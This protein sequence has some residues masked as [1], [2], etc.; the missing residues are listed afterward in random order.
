MKVSIIIGWLICTLG[1]LFY[2]YEYLLR[3]EPSVM[4]PEF[5]HQFEVTAAGLGLFTALYYY[6]YMPL[7]L[8]VGILID[9]FGTRIILTLAISSCAFGSFLFGSSHSIYAAGFG[10]F[11]IGF[12]SAFA[13]VGVL[14]LAAEWLPKHHFALFAGCAVA[15]GMVG[16]M[17][18]DVELTLLIQRVGW[19][20]T[21]YIG[22]VIGLILIPLIWLLVRDAP[23]WK[24]AR[25][26]V[27]VSFRDGF[28]GFWE[29]LR[30]PQ[31]WIAGTIGCMLYLSLS[32]FAELWGISFLEKVYALS[33]EKSALACSMVFAGWLIGAPLN[34]WLS[35]KNKTRKRPIFIGGFL[36]LLVITIVILKPINF[37]FYSLMSL[38]F[39][40]G[41]FS[42]V[43]IVCFAIGRENNPT[44]IA[45][46][47]VAFTNLLVMAGGVIFQ[48]L[49]GWLL[50]LNWNHKLFNGI[51]NYSVHDYQFTFLVLPICILISLFLALFLKDTL[52]PDDWDEFDK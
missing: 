19:R 50:D 46:T 24:L 39:L 47:A 12:G 30:N 33:A 18:G 36:S 32:A 45:A 20:H 8:V 17:V 52:R 14:K 44:R 1:A 16:A 7:Q 21:L 40:F 27:R 41:I 6:A 43:Q 28:A 49:L 38:L 22:T 31:M 48:P 23:Q 2:G 34:G 10:R 37:S 25:K 9:R 3:I 29:I 26:N 11:L 42:S 15:L 13:F 4:M 35:D 51:P 5:M